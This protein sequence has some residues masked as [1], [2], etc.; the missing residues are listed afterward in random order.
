MKLPALVLVLAFPLFGLTVAGLL[1]YKAVAQKSTTA[2]ENRLISRGEYIVNGVARCG[3]CHTPLPAQ[4]LWTGP[5]GSKA[6]R[7]GLNQQ[8]RLPTGLSKLLASQALFRLVI[9]I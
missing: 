6:L 4:G 3:E 2:T 7:C 9:A 1:S 5:A 8:F